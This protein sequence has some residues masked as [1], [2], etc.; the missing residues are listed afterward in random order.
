MGHM[1]FLTI[2]LLA[3]LAACGRA[4]P[5][6]VPAT[7][8]PLPTLATAQTNTSDVCAGAT[9]SGARKRFTLEQIVP[10]LDTVLEVSA[11][12]KNN[13]TY[14]VEYDFRE[15]EGNEYVPGSVVYERGIDDGDG[16]AILQCYFL[17]ENGWDAFMIG[18]SIES[19]VGS[20]VCGVNTSEGIVTLEGEGHM[21]GPF[22]SMADLAEYYISIE[23]MQSGGT[24]RTIKA[25][26]V[27]QI[28]TDHTSP[29][30]L[31]LPWESHQY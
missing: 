7:F 9:E 29:S 14:D 11:F 26:Q 25:S 5:P 27:I 4:T 31:E 23:W 28:T 6:T 20:N 21:A 10:C 18:L 1:R 15:H 30:V 17:E 16:Y 13:V 12:L 2:L 22:S 3:F 24:L 8:T 19:L